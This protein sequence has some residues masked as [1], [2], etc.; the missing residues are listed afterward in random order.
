M[1]F[2]RDTNDGRLGRHKATEQEYRR[3]SISEYSEGSRHQPSH[4]EVPNNSSM[5]C[6]S[7]YS[8]LVY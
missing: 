2:H 7:Y 6:K 4:T 8:S 3:T 1:L 5:V